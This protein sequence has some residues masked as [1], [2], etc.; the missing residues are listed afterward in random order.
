MIIVQM[1]D[2]HVVAEGELRVLKVEG[3][4]RVEVQSGMVRVLRVDN[5]DAISL[6]KSSYVEVSSHSTALMARPLPPGPS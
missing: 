1:T 5:G 4:I 3:A 2:T 6:P